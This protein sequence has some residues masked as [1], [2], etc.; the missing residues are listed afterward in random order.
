MGKN[1]DGC[2]RPDEAVAKVEFDDEIVGKN[3]VGRPEE[4]NVVMLMANIGGKTPVGRP[5]EA[6]KVLFMANIGGKTPEG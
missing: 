6:K 3:P 1:P 2:R 5:D 4:A